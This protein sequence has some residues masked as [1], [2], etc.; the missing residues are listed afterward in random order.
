VKLGVRDVRERAA[1]ITSIVARGVTSVVLDAT[2]R[3]ELIAP[4][5]SA[6]T[7]FTGL[8]INSSAYNLIGLA[9]YGHTRD[10]IHEWLITFD[11]RRT[12]ERVQREAN[13]AAPV[14][15]RLPDFSSSC[16]CRS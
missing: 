1:L 11:G 15:P 4:Q 7:W 2:I 14:C 6:F 10:V 16:C 5:D 9:P 12:R 8:K 3:T 13:R